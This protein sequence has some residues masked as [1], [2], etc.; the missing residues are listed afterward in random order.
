M[1]EE[2]KVFENENADNTVNEET[3]PQAEAAEIPAVE[4]PHVTEEP[5]AVEEPQVAEEPA[6]DIVAPEQPAAT[7]IVPAEN[8]VA[9]LFASAHPAALR[10]SLMTSMI[11][12]SITATYSIR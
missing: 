4:E 9:A 10:I 5:R 3:V 6:A 2:N 1:S 7:E 11:S 8:A 12:A